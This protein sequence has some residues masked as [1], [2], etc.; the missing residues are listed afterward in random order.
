MMH[1]EIVLFIWCLGT[2]EELIGAISP[3]DYKE[4]VLRDRAGDTVQTVI[5]TETDTD[6]EASES[7]NTYEQ[8]VNYAAE[9]AGARIIKANPEAKNVD[10]LINDKSDKYMMSPCD[11]KKWVIISLSEDV[12]ASS[13]RNFR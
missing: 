9:S 10:Y 11:A 13:V 5:E 6:M 3:E 7:K 8:R 1:Q 12:R 4:R 2:D